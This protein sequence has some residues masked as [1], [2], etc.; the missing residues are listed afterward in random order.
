MSVC[1][2]CGTTFGCGM[3]DA[4]ASGSPCWCTQLPVLPRSSTLPARDDWAASRCF[5]PDCLRALRAAA[6][7]STTT[8]KPAD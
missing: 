7:Q 6:A 2:R 3:V 5:C 1:P 4:S 8:L